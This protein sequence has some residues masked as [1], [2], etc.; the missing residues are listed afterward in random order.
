L[1]AEGL[2]S[3]GGHHQQS[4]A[5]IGGGAADGLLIGAEGGVAEG[6]VKK[7]GEVR[8]RSCVVSHVYWVLRL[9]L[10]VESRQGLHLGTKRTKNSVRSQEN[11]T[12]HNG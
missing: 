4:V 6:R 3:A 1:V 12:G 9:G 8:H 2:A 11:E 5:A 7:L 10:L